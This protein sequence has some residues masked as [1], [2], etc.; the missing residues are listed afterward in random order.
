MRN[1]LSGGS[2]PSTSSTSSSSAAS[3]SHQPQQSGR[4]D[5]SSSLSTRGH[6]YN[7]RRSR[8][9]T[10][11]QESKEDGGDPN[12]IIDEEV[13]FRRRV[14]RRCRGRSIEDEKK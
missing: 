3:S 14:S 9:P 10:E 12:S 13:R 5:S 6:S 1:A 2:S 4:E 11:G 7:L 8:N